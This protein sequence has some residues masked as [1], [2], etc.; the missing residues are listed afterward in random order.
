AMIADGHGRRYLAREPSGPGC[1]VREASAD[2]GLMHMATSHRIGAALIALTLAGALALPVRAAEEPAPAVE[3]TT[4]TARTTPAPDVVK[5][6]APAAKVTKPRA[7]RHRVVK[8]FWRYRP[9]RVAAADWTWARSHSW[10]ASHVIL[11]V[12]F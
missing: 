9:I 8:R 12:G 11:G 1:S 7:A 3:A 10:G 5:T 2:E 6:A 4:A